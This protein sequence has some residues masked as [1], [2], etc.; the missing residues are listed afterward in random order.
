MH[1]HVSQLNEQKGE[2]RNKN[3][4]A[5]HFPL[6]RYGLEAVGGFPDKRYLSPVIV[7]GELYRFPPWPSLP[8]GSP[9]PGANTRGTLPQ[10]TTTVWSQ[11]A[12]G[13]M[14]LRD[15]FSIR[16]V[17]EDADAILKT[18][19]AWR[20][21][22]YGGAKFTRGGD[23]WSIISRLHHPDCSSHISSWTSG[24]I[25]GYDAVHSGTRTCRLIARAASGRQLP[26]QST[27]T[28]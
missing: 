24:P 28:F 5:N 2:K 21:V 25:G 3:G 12:P 9:S 15:G 1:I 23:A 19:H 13:H 10:F 11:K 7:E 26:P 16:H 27:V 18:N 22:R 8:P 4:K 14:L 20:Y 17:G 6:R